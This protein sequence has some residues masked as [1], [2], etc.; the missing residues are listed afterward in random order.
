MSLQEGE[1]RHQASPTQRQGRRGPAEGTALCKPRTEASE[2]IGPADTLIGTSSLQ[3]RDT[4]K[5]IV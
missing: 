1:V 3:N 5:P 4:M 2:G